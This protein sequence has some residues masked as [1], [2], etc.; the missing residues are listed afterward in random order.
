MAEAC[1]SHSKHADHTALLGRLSRVEGQ[2]RGVSRM[3]ESDRYC[4]DILTQI[5]AIKSALTAVEREV[6]KSH[7]DHCVSNAIAAGDKAEQ[8]QKISELV[9][10]LLKA[11]R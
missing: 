3:I 7:A 6:L 4:L 9:G 1:G 11:V 2:V 10:L 5:S 8:D